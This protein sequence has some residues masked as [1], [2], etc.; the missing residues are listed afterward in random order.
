[1]PVNDFLGIEGFC[2]DAN[3]AQDV[4]EALDRM[5]TQILDTL[6]MNEA[7]SEIMEILEDAMSRLI[8]RDD[9]DPS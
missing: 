8:D 2:V 7:G 1:M 5:H 9:V 4:Y 6:H 3:C